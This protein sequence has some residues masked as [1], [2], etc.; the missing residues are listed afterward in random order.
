MADDTGSSAWGERAEICQASI[1]GDPLMPL[2]AIV[3]WITALLAAYFVFAANAYPRTKA[4]VA[5]LAALSFALTMWFV[6]WY[7]AGLLLQIALI[8]ALLLYFKVR[9]D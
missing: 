2:G 7:L 1:S 4:L 8:I 6:Q 5:A 3:P 9:A